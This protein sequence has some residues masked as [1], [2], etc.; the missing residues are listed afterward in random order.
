MMRCVF[1]TMILALREKK[2]IK[3][4]RLNIC[5]LKFV[6]E[7]GG[8]ILNKLRDFYDVVFLEYFICML[9]VLSSVL[10]SILLFA[11]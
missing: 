8:V 11:R 6:Q 10:F 7:Y 9:I 2:I 1:N 5:V 4:R 3:Y